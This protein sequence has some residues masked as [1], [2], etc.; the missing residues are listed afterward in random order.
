M[1]RIT[2]KLEMS[3]STLEYNTM[4]QVFLNLVTFPAA[5]NVF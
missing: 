3:R 2:Q 1:R 5:S 4:S